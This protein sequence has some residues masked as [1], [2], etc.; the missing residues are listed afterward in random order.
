MARCIASRATPVKVARSTHV[1]SNRGPL[2]FHRT[3]SIL[4][5]SKVPTCA[6]YTAEA[7]AAT[8]TESEQKTLF[9]RLGGGPAVRAAVDLFYDKMMADPRVNY[10]FEGIDMK[11]QRAHQAAFLTYAMGGSKRYEGNANMTTAHNRLAKEM[12]M[13]MEHFDIVVE[14]IGG[15]LRDLHV[16]EVEIAEAAA[17][18][19]TLRPAFQEA[20]EN[21]KM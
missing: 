5:R 9:N 21:A 12:G 3:L 2:P 18:V 1:C 19:E 16:S 11:K 17:V 20:I 14:H 10:F 7:G 13:R 8:K 6:T 15:A 4:K